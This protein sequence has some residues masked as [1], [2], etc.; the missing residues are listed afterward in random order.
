MATIE[1][2]TLFHTKNPFIG[3]KETFLRYVDRTKLI[4]RNIKP[5]CLFYLHVFFNFTDTERLPPKEENVLIY[6]ICTELFRDILSH[7]VKPA[8]LDLE[9]KS[10]TLKLISASDTQSD[11]NFFY[12]LLRNMCNISPHKNG[13]GNPPESRDKCAAACIDRI[14]SKIDEIRSS[15]GGFSMS[16]SSLRNLRNDIVEVERH[17]LDGHL[18]EERVDNLFSIDTVNDWKR[19]FRFSKFLVNVIYLLHSLREW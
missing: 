10:Q 4:S 9:I 2:K 17:V 8:N 5:T 1:S 7:F 16:K 11:L 18:Y 12:D 3:S 19:A 14:K 15:K 13:W 6:M